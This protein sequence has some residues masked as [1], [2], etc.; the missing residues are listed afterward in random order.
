MID[1]S[2]GPILK[3]AQY[4]GWWA[5]VLLAGLSV[6]V[7]AIYYLAQILTVLQ[8]IRDVLKIVAKYQA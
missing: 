7:I 2:S 3:D 1:P 8:Q 4:Y 5:F 6:S